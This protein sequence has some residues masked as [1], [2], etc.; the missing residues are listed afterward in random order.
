M[1]NELQ[2]SESEQLVH[3]DFRGWHQ[4]RSETVLKAG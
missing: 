3:L 4:R 2:I 1:L